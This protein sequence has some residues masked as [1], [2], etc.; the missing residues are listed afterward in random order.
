MSEFPLIYSLFG[1]VVGSFLNVCI[2]RI[3]RHESIVFPGSHC[4]H[5]GQHIRP[6]DN[7][8]LLSYFWLRGKC[9]SCRASISFQYP[10]VEFLTGLAFF[11][12]AQRWN[13][14]MPTL[15]N[16]AFLSVVIILVFVDFHHQILPDVLT[17]PGTLLGILFSP[18]QD[19]S[20]FRDTLTFNLASLLS[21]ESTDRL[22]PWIGSAFGALISAGMLFLVDF[23]YRAVRKRHG[24]G[25]G[26]VKMMAMVGAFLGWRLA[27]LTVFAGS[28]FGSIVGVLL[29]AFRGKNLQTKLPFGTFLGAGA[30]L[31]LFF[32]LTFI[33]WYTASR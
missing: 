9:R 11:L 21:Q 22:L 13:A 28:F 27:L 6:Y 1:L 16:S 14:A 12:C 8:P 20:L 18:F 4:P 17:L 3:P 10:L 32:G 23:A 2:Y 5:C 25:L 15:V 7:V 33:A 30:A 19:Q 24:L 26:D 31:A 29:I